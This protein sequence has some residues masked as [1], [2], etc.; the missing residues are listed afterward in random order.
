[1]TSLSNHLS[2]KTKWWKH[3]LV[4][5]LTYEKDATIVPWILVMHKCVVDVQFNSYKIFHSTVTTNLQFTCIYL[6]F[7]FWFSAFL[8]LPFIETPYSWLFYLTKICFSKYII[9]NSKNKIT[10][11]FIIC[12]CYKNFTQQYEHNIDYRSLCISILL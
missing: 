11:H 2:K 12:W 5:V 7:L 9:K 10:I 1:M 3:G 8:T 4:R 6:F